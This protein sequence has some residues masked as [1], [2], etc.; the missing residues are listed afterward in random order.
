VLQS[1]GKAVVFGSDENSP[2][3][4]SLITLFNVNL[5]NKV[6]SRKCIILCFWSMYFKR[7]IY[8]HW[9]L[10]LHRSLCKLQ[11]LGEATERLILETNGEMK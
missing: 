6:K 7:R 1:L 9:K 11:I 8:V 3:L 4:A 2:T 5:E 10:E